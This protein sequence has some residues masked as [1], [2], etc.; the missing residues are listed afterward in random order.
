M[1][2]EE[3]K[4]WQER[5]EELQEKLGNPEV[6]RDPEKVKQL[7]IEFSTV[8]KKLELCSS[9]HTIHRRIQETQE[10]LHDSDGE[11][12]AAAEEELKTLE[13]EKRG[14]EEKL[15]GKEPEELPQNVIMEIRAGAGGDEASLFA[16]ELFQM[17]TRFAQKNGWETVILDE[18][19]SDLKGYKEVIFEINGSHA[20]DSLRF[21]SGVHRIQRIPETEKSGRIHTSTASVAVLPK[22]REVD[23]E[24]RPQ[25]IKI[26][27]YRSSGPGG[28][29]V[30]KVETAVRITH[31]PS[32]VVI[33][34][35][36]SRS[37]QKNREH[38]MSI[39]RARLFDAKM[40]EEAKKIARERKEQIGT[41]DRSE[42]IRTYNFPQDRITDHRVKESWHNIASV[43]EGNIEPI[44]EAIRLKN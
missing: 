29:N 37:Q 4:K 3:I 11:I 23:V 41:G 27:F 21:E 32:G 15:L 8:Q 13:A 28:Q 40:Q 42:K 19:K 17:Y 7:S 33:Q 2:E 43:L 9:L 1:N 39:L 34:S 12:R 24:I 10:M 25:D 31:V 5:K 26:E 14:L 20:Y 22:A 30:N 18:S 38:A 44:V 6:L 35:Q 16:R 36:D